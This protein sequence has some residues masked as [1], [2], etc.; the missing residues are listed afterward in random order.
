MESG[1][2]VGKKTNLIVHLCCFSLVT[3]ADRRW[4][5]GLVCDLLG[6]SSTS[7]SKSRVAAMG[8]AL[9]AHTSEQ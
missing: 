8:R 1:I 4:A 9:G 3:H 5:S 6:A 2:A 7:I